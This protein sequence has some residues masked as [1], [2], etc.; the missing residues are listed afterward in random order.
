MNG[1]VDS[2]PQVTVVVTPRDRYSKV[3]QCVADLY[4]HTD[5]TLFTLI[6]LDLGYPRRDLEPALAFLT[7]KSNYRVLDYGMIIPMEA[8]ARVRDEIT[9]PFAVFLDNDSRVLEGWLPPLLDA[10]RETGAAVINPVTL[11]AAGVDE[12]AGMRTHLFSNQL[13]VVK[14]GEV[15]YLIEHKTY[16]RALPEDLP[17]E[18][19]DTESFE[20]HCVM[21]R[22]D[23]LKSLELPLMTIRE[24]L[25]IGI[26]LRERGERAVVQPASRIVFDNLGTRARLSDLRYFNLRWNGGITEASSRLF[27]RRWGYRFYSE[28]AIYNW[29]VRRRLFLL[30]RWLGLPI[31]AANLAD[32]TLGAIR[33]R[34]NP[35]W[36][37]IANP[38]AC[39]KPLYETIP[40]GRIEQLDHATC[41]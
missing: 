39:A 34:L 14:V 6:V 17:T 28:Q 2:T 15:P 38:E 16:R 12:G 29:A 18:I 22:T 31:A 26:Q 27:E 3:A 41:A 21:F 8:M 32:R 7:T 24:H 40:S 1:E 19:T 9:T 36:N 11:E 25:D 33:R 30:L 20:L 37:P 35:V 10:A 23:V 4:M 5:E 13:R